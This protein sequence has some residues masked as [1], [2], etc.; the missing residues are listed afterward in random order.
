MYDYGYN[1]AVKVDV[2]SWIFA[3][4]VSEF[5]E[6]GE[7]REYFGPY[8]DRVVT[9]SMDFE[10]DITGIANA[11]LP[12]DTFRSFSTR[13]EAIVTEYPISNDR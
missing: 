1:Y 2:L 3:T 6:N 5:F 8:Q 12:P 4:Q 13:L 10:G 11:V 7:G 9:L